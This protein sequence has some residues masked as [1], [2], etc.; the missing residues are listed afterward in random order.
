MESQS[1]R[2]FVKQNI[3]SLV[4]IFITAI[5]ITWTGIIRTQHPFRILPLYVSLF[6]GMLQANASRYAC[7][8]G[9]L[10]SILYAIVYFFLGLYAS[11]ASALLTSF[12]LQIA[13]FLR[14]SKH[15]YKHSTVFRRMTIKQM[16]LAVFIFLFGFL[17][18]HLTMT[19]AGSSYRLWDNISTLFGIAVLILTLLSFCEYAWLMLVSGI[20]NIILNLTVMKDHPEHITY[21]VYSIYSLI[22]II[23]Q[24]FTV[25]QL[26]REQQKTTVTT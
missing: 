6:V 25:C 17:I 3:V 9:G 5:L 24:F 22:C 15:S 12:P 21:V 11:A 14:W 19:W 26:Y 4:L 16:I 7:L 1:L 18:L 23:R 8:V 2:H 10:N 13:T 20:L